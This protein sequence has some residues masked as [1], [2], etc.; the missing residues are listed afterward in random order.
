MYIGKPHYQAYETGRE[1]GIP[2]QGAK[3]AKKNEKSDF[4]PY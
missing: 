2:Y 3:L 4:S 1:T